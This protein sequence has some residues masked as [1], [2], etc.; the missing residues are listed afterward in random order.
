MAPEGYALFGDAGD[1]E[2][3]KEPFVS[4]YMIEA[5]G[6]RIKVQAV[7]GNLS[8]VEV[9]YEDAEIREEGKI[10][11]EN[12][13]QF[14]EAIHTL[15]GA[16]TLTVE[17][18][19]D[20]LRLKNKESEKE[21]TIGSTDAA[22]IR[23]NR[24]AS[25]LLER[26]EYNR[27]TELY[28]GEGYALDIKSEINSHKLREI[29]EAAIRFNSEYIKFEQHFD[30]KATAEP[31]E[32]EESKVSMKLDPENAEGEGV[33]RIEYGLDNITNGAAISESEPL[34]SSTGR[35]VNLHFGEDQA[36]LIERE[37]DRYEVKYIIA[38]I[39]E[40]EDGGDQ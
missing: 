31:Q 2:R 3:D 38:S 24:H 13:T 30:L 19:G 26:I 36:L 7:S 4:A 33:T 1:E 10:A 18:R 6:D 40:E 27:E 25:D 9:L 12:S 14:R 39:V 16:G 5:K 11:V 21:V 22:G 8:I 20:L 34:Y 32:S 17:D 29:V 15:S 35:T 28:E 23:S 37:T